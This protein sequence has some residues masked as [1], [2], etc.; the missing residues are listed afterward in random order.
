M[1][2]FILNALFVPLSLP[3]SSVYDQGFSKYFSW[4]SFFRSSGSR[5]SQFMVSCLCYFLY[6]IFF[7]FFFFFCLFKFLY[8]SFAGRNCWNYCRTSIFFFHCFKYFTSTYL[9]KNL[10]QTCNEGAILWSNTHKVSCARN[11]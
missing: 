11:C 8:N 9:K 4:I 1:M 2:V 7:F 5:G 6:R 10:A 3:G